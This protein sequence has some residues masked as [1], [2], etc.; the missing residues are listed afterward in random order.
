MCLIFFWL[1]Q[2]YSVKTQTKYYKKN[3]KKWN[4]VKRVQ[5]MF[6]SESLPLLVSPLL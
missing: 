2:S 5:E 1:Y 4:I 6:S 3:K